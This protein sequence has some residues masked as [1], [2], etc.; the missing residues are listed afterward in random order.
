MP[1]SVDGHCHLTDLRIASSVDAVLSRSRAAGVGAWV[2]GGVDPAD[3]DRQTVLK[4]RSDGVLTSF[5]VHPWIVASGS[6]DQL[7]RQLELLAARATE[8]DA[9]G[10]TGLDYGKR[11]GDASA[12]ARQR[13]AFEAHLQLSSHV[14]KPLVLHI[15][16]AHEDAVAALRQVHGGP[17]GM[18]HSFSG[19]VQAMES[20]VDLGL[21][22]SISGG[23]SRNGFESLKRAVVKVPPEFLVVET[24]AP[25]Q[26][27]SWCLPGELNEPRELPKIAQAIADLRGENAQDILARSRQNLERIFPRLKQMD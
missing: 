4:G 22:I 26:A 12:R 2:I 23:V 11:G 3:W 17:K 10:E 27:P 5:G 6:E 20:Y 15:V 16:Q 7:D 21:L 1:S 18:V 25:D 9:I 8:P 14:G 24:D 19:A 13:R